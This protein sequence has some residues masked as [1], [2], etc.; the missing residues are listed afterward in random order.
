MGLPAPVETSSPASREPASASPTVPTWIA[1][2]MGAAGIAG[3]ATT[4]WL[5]PTTPATTGSAPNLSLR[6]SASSMGSVSRQEPRSPGTH[7]KCA[8]LR[9][10]PTLGRRF[11]TAHPVPA[12]TNG[13]V[14]LEYV[15]ASRNVLG[16][17]AAQ[18]D[19]AASAELVFSEM[20]VWREFVHR[21]CFGPPAMVGTLRTPNRT[22][23][24]M[25][26][27]Q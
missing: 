15:V 26:R 9:K 27:G 12:A 21:I 14:S 1:A 17:S 2:P 23:H 22:S 11:L 8:S 3:P 18:M 7:V 13:H 6:A 5:A 19:V 20:G 24:L 10:R 16:L 25:A 4:A